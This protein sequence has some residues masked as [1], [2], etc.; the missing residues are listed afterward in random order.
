MIYF[1]NGA[2]TFPKPDTVIKAMTD[3]MKNSGGNPGRSGHYLSRLSNETVHECRE[4]MCKYIKEDNPERII[5][6]K[7]DNNRKSFSWS[8]NRKWNR[9]ISII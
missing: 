5:F 9:F 7:N 4:L 2:T 6:T 8:S 3:F 1:D